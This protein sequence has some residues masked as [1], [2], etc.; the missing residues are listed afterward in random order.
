[1]VLELRVSLAGIGELR[2][3]FPT[4]CYVIFEEQGHEVFLFKVTCDCRSDEELVKLCEILLKHAGLVKI[5][6][7]SGMLSM[8]Q[9]VLDGH[10]RCWWKSELG[11]S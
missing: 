8:E 4:F 11:G 1:L 5:E 7:G 3:C 2:E 6:D 9:H 10:I